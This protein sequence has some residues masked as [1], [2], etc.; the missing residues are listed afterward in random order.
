MTL[1]RERVSA[2]ASGSSPNAQTQLPAEITE[3]D[4]QKYSNNEPKPIA[5]PAGV[6]AATSHLLGFQAVAPQQ[7]M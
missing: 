2:Q 7:P 5:L 3:P 4:C 1:F 6:A